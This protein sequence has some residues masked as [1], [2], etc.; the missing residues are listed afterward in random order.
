M[1]NNFKKFKNSSAKFSRG[2]KK[3]FVWATDNL[4]RIVWSDGEKNDLCGFIEAK[5][6]I[7][8][9]TA[10]NNGIHITTSQRS[11]NLEAS[12]QML[13]MKWIESLR[14]LQNYENRGFSA[15]LQEISTDSKLRKS[16]KQIALYVVQ[17]LSKG[18]VF[19][20]FKSKNFSKITEKLIWCDKSLEKMHW[21]DPHDR[22]KVK[23]SLEM[24]EICGLAHRAQAS[25][26]DLTSIANRYTI[27]STKR[28]LEL[29]DGG[30]APVGVRNSMVLKGPD[31]EKSRSKGS[32]S[33]G[34]MF[35][36]ALLFYLNHRDVFF[37]K[38][39]EYSVF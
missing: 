36:D 8:V 9:K 30:A 32:K 24:N 25:A 12:N 27:L 13:Q 20:K 15:F 34:G 39:G 6:I 28:N 29:E 33:G 3:R 17:V 38:K 5:D 11:V 7:S 10:K 4:A 37:T 16:R 1:G 2:E 26:L 19:A 14:W 21:S 31:E 18:H 23:N 35:I 22:N